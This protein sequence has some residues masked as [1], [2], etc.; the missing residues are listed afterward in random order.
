MISSFLISLREG[1]EAALVVGIVLVYLNR[2]GRPAL[3]RFVWAGVGL[4]TALSIVAA[5]ALEH[6][7]ISE[8]GFEGLMLL[9][10]AGFVVTMIVW[11]NKVARTL[12][13]E[14]ERRV[15]S[16]AQKSDL[17]AGLGVGTFVFLMVLREGAE[18]V[19]ILRAVELS[20]EGLMVWL[21]T[22]LGLAVAISVGVFFFQGTLKIP[23][24]RFFAATSVILI[25]VATQLAITG[26]HELSE[27]R[28]IPSSK[29]EMALVGPI[30]QND[31][32][33][34]V[35]I[36]GVAALV[37]L[38]E[39]MASSKSQAVA[40]DSNQ[41]DLSPSALNQAG[42]NQAERRKLSWERNKQR[43]WMFASAIF[44]FAVILALTADFVYARVAAAPPSAE[45]LMPH[46]D[47]VQVPIT[48]VSDGNLHFF[49][50]EVSNTSLRFIV[51]RK[52][53]GS[54]GTALDACMICGWSGFHQN[55]SNVICR[56]CGSAIYV[57][58]IG[59]PGGCNPVGVPS[60]VE[61][62]DL[63]IDLS[64]LVDAAR[65]VPN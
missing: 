13:K 12:R 44:F 34:F 37:I 41:S 7:Q 22:G 32:F 39:F 61:G 43:R 35:V 65:N 40:A 26:L 50:T 24:G 8:D 18:L 51:I 52:P 2:T 29:R 38:R 33:F 10:A 4:A 57:P 49:R 59:Q 62:Q 30:V 53:D 16:F 14:I 56:N 31:F 28:W 60:Q 27:A 54:W 17:A 3:V 45:L 1:L 9:L 47:Q 36:L 42:S 20:S 19:L 46:G 15:D 21:G 6:W 63:V 58:T 55:G 25:V 64:A 23:I 48:E 11:M 5:I